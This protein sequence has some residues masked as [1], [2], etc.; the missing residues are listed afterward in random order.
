MKEERKKLSGAEKVGL[1]RR[2]LVE[3]EEVSKVCEEG[4]ISPRQFYRWQQELFEGGA[5][6][7]DGQ[8]GRHGREVSKEAGKVVRLEAKLREKDEVLAE[9]MGEYVAL[10]KKNG[11]I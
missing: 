3:G 7:L 6:V 8:R 4:G 2:H 9:L 5:E 11:V 1:I 10:K